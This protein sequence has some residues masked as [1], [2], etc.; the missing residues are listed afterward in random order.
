[1]ETEV[2]AYTSEVDRLKT[3]SKKIVESSFSVLPT[4]VSVVCGEEG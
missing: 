4:L 1:M 3:L 2:K